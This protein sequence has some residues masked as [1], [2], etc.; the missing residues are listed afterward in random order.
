[1]EAATI[2]A[3]T[4]AITS[5]LLS[6]CTAIKQLH[7]KHCKASCLGGGIEMDMK[8]SPKTS[9]DIQNVSQQQ[10]NK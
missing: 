9:L 5:L 1:M 3:I 4:A 7:M 2:G 6:L 10:T 8:D